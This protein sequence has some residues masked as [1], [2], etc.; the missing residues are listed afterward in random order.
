MNNKKKR[1]IKP[2]IKKTK[3]RGEY[4]ATGCDKYTSPPTGMC[5]CYTGP[6]NFQS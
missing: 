6:N 1:W 5:G 2:K 4:A 3:L